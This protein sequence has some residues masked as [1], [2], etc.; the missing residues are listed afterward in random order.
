MSHR[1]MD[2][3]PRGRWRDVGTS[4]AERTCVH[5]AY[6]QTSAAHSGARFSRA[7]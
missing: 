1:R 4:A 2:G 3:F 5:T 6:T 7:G